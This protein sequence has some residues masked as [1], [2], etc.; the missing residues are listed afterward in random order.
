MTEH[1]DAII[2]GVRIYTVVVGVLVA[3]SARHSG[4]AG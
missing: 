3:S 1:A 2:Q 4:A